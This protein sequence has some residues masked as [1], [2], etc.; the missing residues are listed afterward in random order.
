MMYKTIRNYYQN[1]TTKYPQSFTGKERDSETGFSYFGARYYDSDLMT[2]WLSVDPMADKY[3]NISPYAYCN[4]N[5]VK[6]VDPNG[7]DWYEIENNETKQKEIKWTDYK[8]QEEMNKNKIDGTYLGEA[9][10]YFQGSNDEKLGSDGKMTSDDA[11]CANVTIYGINGKDD[12]KTYK[13]M[14]TPQSDKYSTLNEGD[15]LAFYQDMATSPYGE[16]GAKAKNFEPALTYRLKTLNGDL[17]LQGTKNGKNIKMT[18]IFF[19]RTNWTGYAANS[20]KGCLI[21]D[22]R[23]WK[24]VEKQLGKS[25]NIRIRVNR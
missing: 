12:I 24:S 10:V 19:H 7:E 8:S 11:I 9:F 5:P 15:Y 6:L 17:T 1:I 23:Q 20:S 2:G 14:T 25:G 4:W 3:P 21:I 22:G 16:Q 13:G 18:E